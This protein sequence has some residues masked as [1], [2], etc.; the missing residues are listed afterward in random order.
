MQ[1][2][3]CAFNIRA[4]S[5]I[6]SL[7][8]PE[9]VLCRWSG[10]SKPPLGLIESRWINDL[11]GWGGL[12]EVRRPVQLGWLIILLNRKKGSSAIILP[13]YDVLSFVCHG[14]CDIR[15]PEGVDGTP[16]GSNA[17][18]FGRGNV[19]KRRSIRVRKVRTWMT[20]FFFFFLLNYKPKIVASLNA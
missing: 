14:H 12:A 2:H 3:F 18:P 17:P 7:V 10:A 6:T 20:F 9:Y 19:L 15:G 1:L 8:R 4:L 13:A 16:R 11:V 5:H